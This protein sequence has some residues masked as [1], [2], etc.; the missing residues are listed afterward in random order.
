MENALMGLLA[1]GRNKLQH[2]AG[3][4]ADPQFRRDVG[5][6]LLDAG[7]RGAVAGLLGGP[8]DLASMALR[9]LGYRSEA[10]VGGSEWIGRQMERAGMV[11]PQ[12]NTLAELAAGL[13]VPGAMVK[14]GQALSR[15]QDAAM[16]NAAMPRQMHPQAGAVVWHASP[17]KF[18]RFDASKVKTGEGFNGY[19]TGLYFSESERVAGPGGQYFQQF[20]RHPVAA[21]SGGPY[22]YKVDIPDEAIGRM[23]DWDAPLSQQP[24]GAR[25]LLPADK[26]AAEM[27]AREAMAAA[28]VAADAG[29]E[30]AY[31]AAKAREALAR[32]ARHPEEAKGR[33]LFGRLMDAMGETAKYHGDGA[34]EFAGPKTSDLLRGMGFSGIRY[35]DNGAAGAGSANFV[36]FDG[37]LPKILDRLK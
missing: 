30:A 36:V 9:P 3:A 18:D 2:M 22:A 4:L 37:D 34:Y 15:A 31:A 11:S 20:G 10:P 6:G 7:N 5:R 35:A 32:M 14:G 16:A 13:A 21:Q 8:V 23:L 24:A 29:D 1:E 12:R 33:D 25:A 27:M 26:K 28:R 17:H 19:G